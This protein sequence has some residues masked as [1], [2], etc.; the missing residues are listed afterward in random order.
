M[1][2][3]RRKVTFPQRIPRMMPDHWFSIDPGGS[4]P[5]AVAS[6]WHGVCRYVVL[7]PREELATWLHALAPSIIVLEEGFAGR[8]NPQAAAQMSETRGVVLAVAELC[9]AEVVRVHPDQW[10][11]VLGLPARRKAGAGT[12]NAAEAALCKLLPG[13]PDGATNADT[14]AAFLIGEAARR[15]WGVA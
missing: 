15:A 8:I 11:G 14:R 6:W 10:R 2:K 1:A 12:L 4:K 3:S 13:V 5:T 9:G 7:V